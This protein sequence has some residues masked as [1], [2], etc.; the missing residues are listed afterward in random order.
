MRQLGSWGTNQEVMVAAA[1]FNVFI[2]VYQPNQIRGWEYAWFGN[3][4][5][6]VIYL[7]NMNE[8]HY[9]WMK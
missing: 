1:Y 8:R 6:R 7:Q 2:V 3:P 9:E 5:H 4:Q